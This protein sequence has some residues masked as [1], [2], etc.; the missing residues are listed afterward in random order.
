MGYLEVYLAIGDNH[1]LVKPGECKMT[2]SR[3]E[4]VRKLLESMG[5]RMLA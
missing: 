1:Q 3:L 5:I 4:K 2:H